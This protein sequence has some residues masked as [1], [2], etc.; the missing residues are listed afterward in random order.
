MK[1]VFFLIVM[2][3][4]LSIDTMPRIDY[5]PKERIIYTTIRPTL[6]QKIQ[7]K[8]NELIRVNSKIEVSLAEIKNSN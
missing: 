4:L 8:R 6:E 3:S 5:K 1:K 7:L 2:F